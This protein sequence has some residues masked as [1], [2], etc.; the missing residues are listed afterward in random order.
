MARESSPRSPSVS[1]PLHRALSAAFPYR[2]QLPL[3]PFPRYSCGLFDSLSRASS[4]IFN[5]LRTLLQ[6]QGGMGIPFF[7]AKP[8]PLCAP[9]LSLLFIFSGSFCF[10]SPAASFQKTPGWGH[11]YRL[12]PALDDCRCAEEY[13][14]PKVYARIANTP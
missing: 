10:Q 14:R 2:P 7:S 5:A 4:F 8:L 3:S 9:A 12:P 11:L 6:K 13:M 1:N